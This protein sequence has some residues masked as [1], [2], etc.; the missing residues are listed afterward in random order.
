MKIKNSSNSKMVKVLA[1][2]AGG[3]IDGVSE[4]LKEVR[5]LSATQAKMLATY[6]D[7]SGVNSHKLK[8]LRRDR[9]APVNSDE[10]IQ[11]SVYRSGREVARVRTKLVNAGEATA[12]AKAI[13]AVIK[14]WPKESDTDAPSANTLKRNYQYFIKTEKLRMPSAK[15][16]IEKMPRLRKEIPKKT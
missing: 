1:L 2:L 6:F 9:G 8:I 5:T 14:S 7:T 4:L 15:W 16:I 10:S 3:K 12:L 13:D 11:E